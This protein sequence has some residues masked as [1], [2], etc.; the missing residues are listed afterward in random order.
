VPRGIGRKKCI[1]LKHYLCCSALSLAVLWIQLVR[2]AQLPGPTI[3]ARGA[4][5]PAG[6][7]ERLADESPSENARS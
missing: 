4:K 1:G 3:G 2:P 7:F 5:K 6:L